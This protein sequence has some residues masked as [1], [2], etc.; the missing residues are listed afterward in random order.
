MNGRALLICTPKPAQVGVVDAVMPANLQESRH[1]S[2]AESRH[3]QE[4]FTGCAVDVNRE[5]FQVTHCPR[6]L[7]IGAQIEVRR[8]CRGE[9]VNIEPVAAE[10]P[11]GLVEAMFADQRR[12]HRR[13]IR[14][15]T[16]ERRERR[17]IDTAQSVAV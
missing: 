13:K 15:G 11:V 6:Q 9:F 3:S 4:F 2:P 17:V 16:L 1:G 12:R 7:G 8:R 5:R 14:V 10:Q